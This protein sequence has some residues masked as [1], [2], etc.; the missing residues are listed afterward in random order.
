MARGVRWLII[1]L[2]AACTRVEEPSRE[3]S[4]T[5][6]APEPHTR[7]GDPEESLITDYNLFVF[8]SFGLLEK[9]VY[10]PRREYSSDAPSCTARL[11]KDAPYT[12]LAAANIGY[13]LRLGS[14]DEALSYRYHMAY[15]DEFSQGMPMSACMMEA[16]AG[17][18]SMIEVHL[19]R[20]MSRVDLRVDRRS[21]NEDVS[22]RVLSVEVCN[23]AS[24][25]VLFG[26]SRVE[27]WGQLFTGGYSKTGEQVYNLNHETLDGMS[28]AVPLYLLESVSGGLVQPYIEVKA[29]YHSSTCHTRPGEVLIYRFYINEDEGNMR[30]TVYP[31]ILKP[32]GTGLE[33]QDGWRLDKS[34]LITAF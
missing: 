10:V 22:L 26:E 31:I 32:S 2:V 25:V 13:E 15:P 27:A 5:L 4:I 23:Q 21:L 30:N 7:S 19:E 11:L 33:C 16:V 8:N 24:S 17:K 3:V 1:L 9:K 14:I 28:G 12:I 6:L 34:A 29:D 18:D 20:L